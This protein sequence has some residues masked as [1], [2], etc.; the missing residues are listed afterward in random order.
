MSSEKQ[1]IFSSNVFV[2]HMVKKY[3]A[4]KQT[5]ESYNHMPNVLDLVLQSSG[6]SKLLCSFVIKMMLPICLYFRLELVGQL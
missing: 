1:T 6:C 5:L 2:Q 3:F 4:K